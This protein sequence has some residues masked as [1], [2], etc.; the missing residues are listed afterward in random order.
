MRYFRAAC[1][2]MIGAVVGPIVMVVVL[3]VALLI[4]GL[5]GVAATG[6][7]GIGGM[8]ILLPD[9]PLVILASLVG[10]IVGFVWSLR[11]RTP[12]AL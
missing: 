6:G 4:F 5:G 3:A 2:G 7:G 11:P 10:F 1:V 9:G 12:A 8:E